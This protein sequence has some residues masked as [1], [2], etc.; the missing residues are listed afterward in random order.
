MAQGKREMNSVENCNLEFKKAGC[1]ISVEKR[2]VELCKEC[3]NNNKQKEDILG[4][5]CSSPLL[6]RRSPVVSR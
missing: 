5:V 3:W 1:G 2:I 6:K 4:Q